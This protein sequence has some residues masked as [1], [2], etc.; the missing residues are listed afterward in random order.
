MPAPNKASVYPERLT[1]RAADLPI[2]IGAETQSLFRR[3]HEAGV[4]V[5]NL[6]E[7][8]GRM[9][10]RNA[11]APSWYLARDSHWSAAGLAL[12]AKAVSQRLEQRGWVSPG[13]IEFATRPVPVRRVGDVIRMLEEP[14]IEARLA[15]ESVTCLQVVHPDTGRV[16][17][18]DPESGI[19]VLGDSFLRIFEQDEPG[20]A[21]FLAHLAYQLRQ[22]VTSIVNDGGAST[23]VRQELF[24]RPDYLKFKKVVVWEFVERD[25]RFGIEG[26]QSVPLPPEPRSSNSFR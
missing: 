18:D 22:P 4:E 1:R 24:R 10:T 14:Q 12:A 21:G 20:S 25:I 11:A 17:Q 23:L 13:H 7:L 19:L 2:A 5:V 9:K 6:F 8:Y 15:S 26:W 3:L 16:Y